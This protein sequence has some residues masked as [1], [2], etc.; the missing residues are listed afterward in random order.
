MDVRWK[1]QTGNSAAGRRRCL[2]GRAPGFTD[3]RVGDRHTRQKAARLAR[4]GRRRLRPCALRAPWRC[5]SGADTGNRSSGDG[6]AGRRLRR[7]RRPDPYSDGRRIRGAL[8]DPR[9]KNSTLCDLYHAPS[10]RRL[11]TQHSSP[12]SVRVRTEKVQRH[13][14]L[15]ADDPAVVSG[16][17]RWNIERV[18]PLHFDDGAVV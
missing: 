12:F 18:A 11:L 14:W 9:P 8:C 16:R 6:A 5:S 2:A 17:S 15:V 3:H 1:T 13:V 7:S 4:H 10:L